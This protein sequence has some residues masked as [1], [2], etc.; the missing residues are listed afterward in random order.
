MAAEEPLQRGAAAR[1]RTPAEQLPWQAVDG[2]LCLNLS[3]N[4]AALQVDVGEA[5]HVIGFCQ[6]SAKGVRKCT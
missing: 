6:W 4:Q 5:P 2:R 3:A 1:K